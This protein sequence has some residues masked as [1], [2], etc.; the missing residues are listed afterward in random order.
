MPQVDDIAGKVTFKIVY[1]GPGLAGRSTNA[2]CIISHIAPECRAPASRVRLGDLDWDEEYGSLSCTFTPRA[3]A[4]LPDR[5]QAWLRLVVPPAVNVIDVRRRN[6]LKVVDGIVFVADSQEARFEANIEALE[7]LKLHLDWYG[8]NLAEVPR[9]LQLNKQ[10]MPD[11]VPTPQL[12]RELRVDSEPVFEA[13]AS[14][15]EG[16]FESLK[17]V[18]KQILARYCMGVPIVPVHKNGPSSL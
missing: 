1:Y 16:V 10:D 13:I 2:Q 7:E 12:I 6:C 11:L 4:L 15:G 9:V 18:V 5:K 14:R 3:L 8:V 17:A